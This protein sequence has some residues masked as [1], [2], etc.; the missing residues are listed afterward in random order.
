MAQ[1]F[2]LRQAQRSGWCVEGFPCETKPN[3]LVTIR[4]I[5]DIPR[6]LKS[7]RAAESGPNLAPSELENPEG[8]LGQYK[9]SEH[10][11]QSVL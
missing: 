2:L 3:F 7:P 11:C 5:E 9:E 10:R 6:G 1:E 8:H 4:D